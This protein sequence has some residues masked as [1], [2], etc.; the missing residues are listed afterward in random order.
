MNPI[1]KLYQK[2]IGDAFAELSKYARPGG[3][4]FLGDSITEFFRANEFFPGAYV[5]NRGIGSDTTEGVLC[6][7]PESVYDLS[8]SKVFILIG[9]NDIAEK[10]SEQNIIGNMWE[11]ITQIQENCPDTQIYLESICPVSLEKSKKIKRGYLGARNN[12]IISSINEKLKIMANEKGITYIDLYSY[13]I[14][15]EGNICLDYTVEGLHLS[16]CG[17]HKVAE[18]LM[19]YVM[20]ESQT[21]NKI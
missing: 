5:I 2:K 3:I 14:N 13:L 7:L 9:T 16:I 21:T 19:P 20:G 8:P 4:V 10:K 17:Y 1:I 15:E 12:E 6:R 11:I 18:I